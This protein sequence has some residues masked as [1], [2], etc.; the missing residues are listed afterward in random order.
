MKRIS[1]YVYEDIYNYLKSRPGKI[2]EHIRYALEQYVDK[3]R[4]SNASASASRK[5]GDKDE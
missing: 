3:M 5:E 2:S 1:L 4:S